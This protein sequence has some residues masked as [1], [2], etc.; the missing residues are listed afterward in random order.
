M[1]W[2][3]QNQCEVALKVALF[4]RKL[5][6]KKNKIAPK[7]LPRQKMQTVDNAKM[8]FFGDFLLMKCRTLSSFLIFWVWH[9]FSYFQGI[10]KSL[11]RVP[12]LLRIN[13]AQC[14]NPFFSGWFQIK[15]D[16]RQFQ[17]KMKSIMAC[18]PYL[19]T[20]Y[21]TPFTLDAKEHQ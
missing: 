19:L 1:A 4:T 10:L 21:F 18:L 6:M 16:V 2:L 7:L 17:W 9:P 5:D 20:V 15:C 8:I 12:Y 3:H 13:I 14:P 11:F